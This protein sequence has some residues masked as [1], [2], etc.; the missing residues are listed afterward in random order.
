M[1]VNFEIAFIDIAI[2]VIYL[3]LSRLIPLWLN[4]KQ[5]DDT[6]GFFLG[7]RNFV[8]PLIGFSL[9]ATNV[10]GASFVGLAGAGYAQG[11]SVYSYEWMAAII[12]IFFVFFMLPFYLKSG[13]FTMPEFLERR[14]DRRS[15]VAFSGLL[16]FFATFLGTAGTLYAGALVGLTMFPQVPLWVGVVVLAV[17]AGV[18]SIFG[19][20]GAVVISD[21]IQA[22]VLLIGGSLVL[23]ATLNAIPSWEAMTE[24]VPE[25]ALHIIQPADDPNLPWPGLLTGLIIIGIYAWTTE[26]VAVQRVLG[27]KNLDHGRWGAIFAGFLKLPILF[28]MILP[29]T[30]A[31]YLFP[32]LQS[33]DMVFPKLVAEL[34]PTGVKGIIL[35]ALVAAITSS[36]DSTLNS[37]STLVT[38]DFVKP[39][40]P[41]ISE[42]G[43][44][45]AGQITTVVVMIIAVIWAPQIIKF[46]S[47][48]NYIQSILSYVTP[49]I[50][51]IFLVGIFWKRANRHGAF[52]T[53]V[54][55]IGLGVVGFFANE[56]A[57]LFPIHFLY[58]ALISFVG[59]IALHVGVSLMTAPE[60]DDKLEGLIWTPSLWKTETE[61]L[62]T[63][64]FWKNYRYL[65][66]LLFVTTMVIV[67]WFW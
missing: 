13:V 31:L 57:G 44:V 15:R 35:A 58:A 34:L 29:G 24:V 7:G 56:I 14:Y 63:V 17:L 1:F 8:W 33:P 42:H 26:Q 60:P 32:D 4:R 18:M 3:V 23:I 46:S 5:K 20:L 9:L 30:M 41:T 28:L 50:V 12:L 65:A 53:F 61:E 51:A 54:L 47:L 19:G 67:I 43:L 22:V 55:G 21:T 38:M 16:I 36:V 62:K 49:P 2:L 6:S 48:W 45:R 11:I 10:S 52:V 25:R 40:K 59:S 64:P 39:F 66:T 27:A 37:A